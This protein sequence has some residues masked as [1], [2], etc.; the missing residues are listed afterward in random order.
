MTGLGFGPEAKPRGKFLSGSLRSPLFGGW[1]W[2]VCSC[3][4][5]VAIAFIELN[6]ASNGRLLMAGTSTRSLYTEQVKACH[7]VDCSC[8]KGD[9]SV[10]HVHHAWHITPSLR[11][12]NFCVFLC[13]RAAAAVARTYTHARISFGEVIR[14]SRFVNE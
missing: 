12:H 1:Y 6:S 13:C 2:Y 7:I 11:N 8:S 3:C 4:N 14:W 5:R 10:P 9:V